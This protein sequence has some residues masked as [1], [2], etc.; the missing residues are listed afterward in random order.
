MAWKSFCSRRVLP[1]LAVLA[2]LPY[3]LAQINASYMTV[4]QLAK[5]AAKRNSSV[6]VKIPCVVQDGFH[7]NSNT[8]TEEYLIPLKLT[9][10][11]TGALEA[12]AV[13]YPKPEMEKYE[14][15]DKP[16]S[17]LTG[18][19][20][21]VANF[22]VAANAQAGPGMAT[23]KLR[24]QACSNRACYQPKTIDIQIPYQVQ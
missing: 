10:T 14:F 1:L 7:V 20:D 21:V 15:S 23:G 8:P 3:L 2:C 4:G 13:V 11:A 16:I 17:V 22:K 24:Y 18:K 19:F 9:W 12:G 5:V 6:Q